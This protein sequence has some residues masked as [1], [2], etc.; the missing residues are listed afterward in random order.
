MGAE[1]FFEQKDVNLS[2]LPQAEAYDDKYN[3]VTFLREK[4]TGL[5]ALLATCV[6]GLVVSVLMP[7]GVFWKSWKSL[8][9]AM[10]LLLAIC[11]SQIIIASIYLSNQVIVVS[12][13]AIPFRI[14][15]IHLIHSYIRYYKEKKKRALLGSADAGLYSPTDSQAHLGVLSVQSMDNNLDR[16][17]GQSEVTLDLNDGDMNISD[18]ASNELGQDIDRSVTELANKR[19]GKKKR[20]NAVTTS[21]SRWRRK[22]RKGRALSNVQSESLRDVDQK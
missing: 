18:G 7:I 5:V 3:R 4:G 19:R 9:T 16:P 13:I 21:I 11:V 2:K 1:T 14:Y 12:L 17:Q 8:R 6:V 15:E 10:G 22:A 20:D